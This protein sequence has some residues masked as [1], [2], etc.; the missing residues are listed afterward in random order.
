M[1]FQE[2]LILGG[3]GKVAL[4]VE[5][6][7]LLREKIQ[8]LISVNLELSKQREEMASKLLL[9]DRQLEELRQRCERFE[10]DRKEAY[11]RLSALLEKIERLT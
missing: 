8:A 7:E 5:E 9:R 11:R 1:K 4:E 6:M 10:R 3:A 2:V